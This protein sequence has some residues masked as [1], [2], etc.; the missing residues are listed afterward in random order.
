MARS[1]ANKVNVQAPDSDYPYGRI[2][3]NDGT[4][5][6]TPVNE[7]VYGDV[8][9][10]F[11]RL[12]AQAGI[13]FNE[14]PDNNYTGFQFFEA[15][16]SLIGLKVVD[17]TAGGDFDDFIEP[18]VY[19]IRGVPTNSPVTFQSSEQ[20][21]PGFLVVSKGTS[22]V[23]VFQH[24]VTRRGTM[25]RLKIVSGAF[26]SWSGRYRFT[27]SSGTWNMD[28]DATKSFAHSLDATKI[29]RVT[30]MVRDDQVTPAISQLDA[31]TSQA[32]Q[33]GCHW[34]STDII[35][36]RLTGG[37]YDSASYDGTVIPSNRCDVEV[38]YEV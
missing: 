13:S 18:G 1:L 30:A 23:D 34:D 8:H 28:T 3:D 29:R 26:Q 27:L 16:S 15:L 19:S 32:V 37:I 12:M 4:G 21:S 2:K 36:E 22:T 7:N 20:T 5:N 14:N 10:F 25:G 11:E 35:L 24:V 17:G 31:Y 9:Q 38:E 6:G 33:G